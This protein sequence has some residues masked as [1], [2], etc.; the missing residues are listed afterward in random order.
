MFLRSWPSALIPTPS[1]ICPNVSFVTK[2]VLGRSLCRISCSHIHVLRTSHPGSFVRSPLNNGRRARK[3]SEYKARA[4]LPSPPSHTSSV[5]L[6]SFCEGPL[7]SPQPISDGSQSQPGQWH[8]LTRITH[9]FLKGD[10]ATGQ[11]AVRLQ[12]FNHALRKSP[13]LIRT[14]GRWRSGGRP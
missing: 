2:S 6:R 12:P 3:G 14:T 8:P 11:E 10:T 9:P 1:S 5:P 4:H 7:R 13:C